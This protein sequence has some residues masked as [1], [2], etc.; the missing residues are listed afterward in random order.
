MQAFKIDFL[1]RAQKP[2]AHNGGE[3]YGNTALFRRIKIVTAGG[4]VVSLPVVSGNAV[5]G[6]MRDYCALKF[7]RALEKRSGEKAMLPKDAFHLLF[8]GGALKEASTAGDVDFARKLREA[9]PVVSLFG[10]AYGN[11]IYPGKIKI[12]FLIPVV[13]EALHLIPPAVRPDDASIPSMHEIMSLDMYTRKDDA[14][15]ES[16]RTFL[17]DNDALFESNQMIYYS[18]SVAAG[19]SFYWQ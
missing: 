18:S 5:R 10:G 4:E 6:S 3:L 16:K 19:T 8:S 12:G 11:T 2:I 13:Q 17:N 9:I 15:D 7:L 14:N 1:L